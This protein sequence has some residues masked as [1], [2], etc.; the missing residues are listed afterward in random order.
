MPSRGIPRQM[1]TNLM[2][3]V[4]YMLEAQGMTTLRCAEP[5]VLTMMHDGSWMYRES[6]PVHVVF[7]VDRQARRIP[8]PQQ[9]AITS[10]CLL[11]SASITF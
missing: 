8:E 1:Y 5:G 7:H 11:L 9:P 2:F 3:L 10:W 6:L 4:Q